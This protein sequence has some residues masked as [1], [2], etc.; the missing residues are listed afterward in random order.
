MCVWLVRYKVFVLSAMLACSLVGCQ[1]AGQE[2]HYS[3]AGQ[4]V[5]M[6]DEEIPLAGSMPDIEH[7]SEIVD[8][9]SLLNVYFGKTHEN[10]HCDG[11][12]RLDVDTSFAGNA[13]SVPIQMDVGLDV[14]EGEAHGNMD[15]TVTMPEIGKQTGHTEV[16]SVYDGVN[17]VLY[18]G[19]DGVFTKADGTH[20]GVLGF[21]D[22]RRLVKED[23][24]KGTFSD[25]GTYYI[26]NCKLSDCYDPL[27]FE[28]LSDLLNLSGS[29]FP[30]GLSESERDAIGSA[31]QTS[32][33]RFSFDKE[34]LELVSVEFSKGNY[35]GTVGGY[36]VT[37]GFSGTY[38]FSDYG[39]IASESVQV[40][41][42]VVS[43]AK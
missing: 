36:D 9:E 22:P 6:P 19:V 13:V 3:G 41:D 17:S 11:T 23:L 33:V 4:L 5:A 24:M 31:F 38:Q 42:E 7:I 34:S 16:Y 21:A 32:L 25:D 2:I 8:T 12:L 30:E 28:M 37:A 14:C 43:G 27:G 18:R 10:F 40:P 20:G 35:S 39:E 1:R 15:G 26:L 29:V